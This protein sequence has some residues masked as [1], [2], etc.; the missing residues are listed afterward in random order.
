MNTQNV[1]LAVS[2][3]IGML[4]VVYFVSGLSPGTTNVESFSTKSSGS[5]DDGDVQIDLTPRYA[6]DVLSVDI[7]VNTHTVSLGM[8][9]LTDQVY[10]EVNGEKIFPRSAPRMGGHHVYGTLE[11]N[12]EETMINGG[13]A[14]VI[15][16]IPASQIRRHEW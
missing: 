1:L 7:A 10:L 15:E 11:F 6:G 12:V 5:Q 14:I 8:I 3:G 2:L 13:F 16:D 9:D 4:F